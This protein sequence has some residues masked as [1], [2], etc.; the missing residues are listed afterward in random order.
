MHPLKLAR[1]LSDISPLTLCSCVGN[2]LQLIDPATPRSCKVT[3]PS[4]W[5]TPFESLASVTSL[6]EFTV[7]DLEPS[8]PTRGKFV[9][10]EAQVALFSAFRSSNVH[11]NS[12]RDECGLRNLLAREQD[13]PH[14]HPPPRRPPARQL[15]P[16]QLPQQFNS[17][18]FTA[19]PVHRNPD[20]LVCKPTR[21]AAKHAN[22]VHGSFGAYRERATW[23]GKRVWCGGWAGLDEGGGGLRATLE[24]A[25]CPLHAQLDAAR[26]RKI[27]K[28]LLLMDDVHRHFRRQK[29]Q[30]TVDTAVHNRLPTPPH[31]HTYLQAGTPPPSA[32][33]RPCCSVV[34]PEKVTNGGVHAEIALAK[35]LALSVCTVQM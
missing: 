11:K 15:R 26:L 30:G 1:S 14:L 2:S 17:D 34:Y 19:L 21:F 5:C 12:R 18:A 33:S 22:P 7:L 28:K 29:L 20:V 23:G 32:C 24:G 16:R 8:G 10:A 35:V 25:P 9:V 27:E 6:V 31:C 3:S 13:L 4:Y